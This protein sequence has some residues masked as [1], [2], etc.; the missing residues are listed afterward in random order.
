MFHR[1]TFC[2]IRPLFYVNFQPT[3]LFGKMHFSRCSRHFLPYRDIHRKPF[4]PMPFHY[5][6]YIFGQL[7][8]TGITYIH[9]FLSLLEAMNHYIVH[10]IASCSKIATKILCVM[11]YENHVTCDSCV[12]CA[13]CESHAVNVILNLRAYYVYP[14][15]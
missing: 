1:L 2:F 15:S 10:D 5:N 14:D 9:L 13:N 8:D 11:N 6:M 7:L 12:D 3:I 4:Q